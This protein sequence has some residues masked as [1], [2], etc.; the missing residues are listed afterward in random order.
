MS[1]RSLTLIAVVLCT[2]RT[3]AAECYDGAVGIN[4][5]CGAGGSTIAVVDN[6]IEGLP[7]GSFTIIGVVG[8]EITGYQRGAVLAC[9]A[10]SAPSAV[11]LVSMPG[12]SQTLQLTAAPL[13]DTGGVDYVIELGAFGD[14]ILLQTAIDAAFAG[15]VQSCRDQL[16]S[17]S[18]TPS[19]YCDD[20]TTAGGCN[21]ASSSGMIAALSVLL[22]RRRRR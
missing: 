12:T 15:N 4:D 11:Q 7:P 18:N 16:Y 22:L 3:A 9:P 20:V 13:T 14:P 19:P 17:V 6:V 1:L 8:D 5:W 10:C 2:A 21:S